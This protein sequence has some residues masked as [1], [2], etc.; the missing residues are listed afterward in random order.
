TC[1]DLF[2]PGVAITSASISSTTASVAYSGTSMAS[3]HVAGVAALILGNDPSLAPST[4]AAAI[5]DSAT[6]DLVVDPVGSPNLL[7]FVA[8]TAAPP[9]VETEPEAPS[10]VAAT[11]VARRTVVVTWTAPSD[12]GSP[13]TSYT[14]TARRSDGRIATFAAGGDAASLR[15]TIR[16]GV[17]TFTVRATN[18]IGN[19]PDSAPTGGVSVR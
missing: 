5:K 13:I 8:R 18:A 12:G 19:S 14:V 9:P 1:V 3:P 6:P 7:L 15:I 2:A 16:R 4:V 10:G 17:Y 11:L